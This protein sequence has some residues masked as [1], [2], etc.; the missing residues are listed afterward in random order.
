MARVASPGGRLLILEFAPPSDTLFGRLFRL[1]LKAAVPLLGLLLAGS[2][3]AYR[4]LSS[5]IMAFNT[6]REISGLLEAAGLRL[7]LVRGLMM[8]AVCLHVARKPE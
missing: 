1:Y 3:G 6:P 4:Y 7:E 2:P 5:S 8:G